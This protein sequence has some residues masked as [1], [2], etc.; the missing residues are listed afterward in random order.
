MLSLVI[1]RSRVYSSERHLVLGGLT[2]FG[3]CLDAGH[4]RGAV[5]VDEAG[6][7]RTPRHGAV[8]LGLGGA[9]VEGLGSD[10]GELSCRADHR[11]GVGW[12]QRQGGEKGAEPEVQSRHCGGVSWCDSTDFRASRRKAST[13]RYRKNPP[14]LPFKSYVG[15]WAGVRWGIAILGTGKARRGGGWKNC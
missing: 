4:F 3:L 11:L 12:H 8:V 9:P 7:C 10:G 6:V 2:C 1:N 14:D 13:R 15:V 5:Y